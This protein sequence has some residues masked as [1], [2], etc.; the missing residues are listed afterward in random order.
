MRILLA[1]VFALIAA[2]V[3]AQITSFDSYLNNL[4]KLYGGIVFQ[5]VEPDNPIIQYRNSVIQSHDEVHVSYLTVDEEYV[6]HDY[7]HYIN[8]RLTLRMWLGELLHFRYNDDGL[9]ETI[10]KRGA[11]AIRLE[12]NYDSDGDLREIE[13]R[14]ED[15]PSDDYSIAI[16]YR[17]DT[18][19]VEGPG[20]SLVFEDGLV[21][22]FIDSQWHDPGSADVYR[23]EYHDGLVRTI[24]HLKR[25]DGKSVL[26]Y[27]FHYD[28]HGERTMEVEAD[29]TVHRHTQPLY[30]TEGRLVASQS[31]RNGRVT[32]TTSYTYSNNNIYVEGE[33]RFGKFFVFNH[34]E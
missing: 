3:S 25:T 20:Y 29:G 10:Q 1:F 5:H 11:G 21:T 33:I 2:G 4:Q 13:V 23:L 15:S 27:T 31:L 18:T 14:Y 19:V 17:R 12:Y 32:G 9:I 34:E 16:E 6:R 22:R 7:K 26:A 8:G 28:E 30:D 24:E